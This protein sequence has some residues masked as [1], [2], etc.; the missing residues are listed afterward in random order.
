VLSITSC[1]PSALPL[2]SEN[3]IVQT[4]ARPANRSR[5][6]HVHLP[7][8][9]FLG[10]GPTLRFRAIFPLALLVLVGVLFW[11]L[12]A[13][14]HRQGTRQ[15]RFPK[16]PLAPT[17]SSPANAAAPSL[18][19]CLGTWLG[20]VYTFLMNTVSLDLAAGK[21]AQLVP[22]SELSRGHHLRVFGCRLHHRPRVAGILFAG[23]IVSWL[24]MMPA[25]KFYGQLAG[26]TPI[27]PST[28]PNPAHARMTSGAATFVMGAGAVAAAGLITL[29]RTLPTIISALRAGLKMFARKEQ[30]SPRPPAAGVRGLYLQTLR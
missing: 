12:S 13:A 6:R 9:I 16:A 2:S 7:A 23:G 3:N 1:A 20:G 27:Y 8:L 10:F 24:V 30:A 21:P 22:R 5:A 11:F 18:A 25:I 26:N 14:A 15:P 29:L 17:S 28:I 19:A 4:P